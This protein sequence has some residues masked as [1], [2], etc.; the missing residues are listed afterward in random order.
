MAPVGRKG[1][2]G[3]CASVYPSRGEEE[4]ERE[5]SFFLKEEDYFY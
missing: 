2:V 1:S 4:R 5:K 3:E